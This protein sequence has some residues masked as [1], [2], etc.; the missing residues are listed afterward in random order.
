MPKVILNDIVLAEHPNPPVVEGNYYF[1]PESVK[2]ELFMDSDTT[3]HCPWKGDA[4]YYNVN[5]KGDA[6]KDVAW[7]YPQPFDKAAHIKDH[8]AFYK[9]KVQI[10]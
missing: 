7:Y 2:N 9:T 5:V 6:V 3:T 1:P 4:K 8:I 10:A